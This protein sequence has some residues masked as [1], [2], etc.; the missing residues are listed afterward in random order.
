MSWVIQECFKEVLVEAPETVLLTSS[1]PPYPT[2]LQVSNLSWAAATLLQ[3]SSPAV[4]KFNVAFQ[5]S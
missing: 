1:P 2:H 5:Y 3:A 4:E